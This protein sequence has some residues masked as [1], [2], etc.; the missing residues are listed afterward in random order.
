MKNCSSSM[1]LALLAQGPAGCGSGRDEAF[2]TQ[3]GAR[4]LSQSC[5]ADTRVA[6]NADKVDIEPALYLASAQSEWI[7]PATTYARCRK[8]GFEVFKKMT[9]DQRP[10]STE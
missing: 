3:A 5:D 2:G 8:N 7:C 6:Y 10:Y 9:A 1:R 4:L